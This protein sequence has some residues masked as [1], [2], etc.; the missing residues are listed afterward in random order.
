MMV[1]ELIYEIESIIDSGKY[2]MIDLENAVD[3][4][5]IRGDE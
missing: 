5:L 4:I 2:S 1:D 3:D